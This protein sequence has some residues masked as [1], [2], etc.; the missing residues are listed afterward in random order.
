VVRPARSKSLYRL[1]YPGSRFSASLG[2]F[3]W[4]Y[5]VFPLTCSMTKISPLT[6]PNIGDL[7]TALTA[8]RPIIPGDT[9]LQHPSPP[10]PFTSSDLPVFISYTNK[11]FLNPS[12]VANSIE[13]IRQTAS[14][15]ATV[16]AHDISFNSI[17]HTTHSPPRWEPGDRE[18]HS[19]TV[20]ILHYIPRRSGNNSSI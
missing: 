6:Y 5:L 2:R 7:V 19:T 17:G 14:S 8:T 16:P 1:S 15:P 20:S 11:H 3:T 18:G 4:F 13:W 12:A 10:S 9:N